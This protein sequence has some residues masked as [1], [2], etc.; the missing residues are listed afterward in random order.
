MP[1]LKSHLYYNPRLLFF[2]S[3]KKFKPFKPVEDSVS[4]V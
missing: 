3:L 2:P 1:F 4:A